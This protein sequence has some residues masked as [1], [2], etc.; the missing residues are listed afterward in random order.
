MVP[1]GDVA[2]ESQVLR[3]CDRQGPADS[4]VQVAG[5]PSCYRALEGLGGATCAVAT[6]E[7]LLWLK[8]LGPALGATSE[9]H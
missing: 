3:T 1:W 6:P 5:P 2:R 7:A 8:T 4:P 9:G